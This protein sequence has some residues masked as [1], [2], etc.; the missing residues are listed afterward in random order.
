[1]QLKINNPCARVFEWI[2]Y[3]QFDNIK[4]VNE[5]GLAIWKNGPLNYNLSE[6][7]YIRIQNQKVGL[8]YLYNSQNMIN[9]ILNK[10]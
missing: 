5:D 4:D 6:N 2:P 3:D 9:Q 10:V 8:R 7:E 1:M